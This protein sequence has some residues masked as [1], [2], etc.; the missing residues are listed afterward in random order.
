MESV[1][2]YFHSK[3]PGMETSIGVGFE[4][5]APRSANFGDAT[6]AAK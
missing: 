5:D 6:L 4:R 3:L 1:I 2:A